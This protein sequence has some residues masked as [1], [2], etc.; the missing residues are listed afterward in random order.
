MAS[1][2]NVGITGDNSGLQTALNDSKRTLKDFVTDFNRKAAEIG[3]IGGK[4]G[5]AQR[6]LVMSGNID[7]QSKSVATSLTK[8]NSQINLA[9]GLYQING[10]RIAMVQA[11]TQAYT[12]TLSDLLSRGLKPDSDSAKALSQEIRKLNA[13]LYVL[14]GPKRATELARKLAEEQRKAGEAATKMAEDK[15]KADEKAAEAARKLAEEEK[16]AAEKAAEAQRKASEKMVADRQKAFVELGNIT[17]NAGRNMTMAVTAP[18]VTVSALSLKAYGDLDALRRGLAIAEG[19]MQGALRR[20]KELK[21][22]Y[23]LPGLGIQESLR[24]DVLLRKAGGFSSNESFNIMKEFGNAIALGGGGKEQFGLVLTQLAQMSTATKV[25]AT[26]LK[27]IIGQAPV[28]A[29]AIK[30]MFGTVN[31]E[32]ISKQLEAAGKGPKEFISMLTAE[33]AK[34]E[35]VTS[36]FKNGIE[37]LQ[38]SLTVAGDIVG[39]V[40]DR[41][42]TL[43]ATLSEGANK[44][45]DLAKWFEGLSETEQTAI[46]GALAFTAATGPMIYAAGSL[47]GSIQNLA[48]AKKILTTALGA[49]RAATILSMGP[50]VAI[51]AAIGLLSFKAYGA[52]QAQKDWSGEMAKANVISKTLAEVNEEVAASIAN[53]KSKVEALLKVARDE[54]KSKTERKTAIEQLRT[55]APDYLGDLTLEKI[56]TDEVVKSVDRYIESLRLKTKAQVLAQ[57][58][59]AAAMGVEREKAKTP[60]QYVTFFDKLA[61]SMKNK[62]YGSYDEI[63]KNTGTRKQIEALEP[64]IIK[65]NALSDAEEEVTADMKRLGLSLSQP[66][67]PKVPTV[68][69][70]TDTKKG[71]S[72]ITEAIN[73]LDDLQNVENQASESRRK[74]NTIEKEGHEQVRKIF[75]MKISDGLKYKLFIESIQAT[76]R[77]LFDAR[78]EESLKPIY[79]KPKLIPSSSSVFDYLG[80]KANQDVTIRMKLLWSED[81][82][83]L[84]D[85]KATTKANRTIEGFSDMERAIAEANGIDLSKPLSAKER[86]LVDFMVNM[87]G[88]LRQG[89]ADATTGMVELVGGLIAGTSGIDQLPQMLLGV[90]GGA[91]QQMGK[92]Y[93]SFGLTSTKVMPLLTN[94]FTSGYGAIAA[95]IAMTALGAGLKAATQKRQKFANGG[96]AYGRIFGV[97]AEAGEYSNARNNPEVIA[98]LNDLSHLLEPYWIKSVRTGM[99]V[100]NYTPPSQRTDQPINIEVIQNDRGAWS[101]HRREDKKVKGTR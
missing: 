90:I 100:Q 8:L 76:E 63:I 13:E 47:A 88:I 35:R 10:D 84:K 28:V 56:K 61:A 68:G 17:K 15:R 49:S 36:G 85:S 65:L 51:A 20:Q 41:N 55:I 79:N 53:E 72:D 75:A 77:K 60:D 22:I 98:P 39:R 99:G 91:F 89:A 54:T 64:L 26:D 11:K 57:Q 96:I 27:P 58:K 31:S 67:V 2:I 5:E 95:G 45:E 62:K 44:V 6:K 7:S 32:Q 21:S 18:L 4:L 92:A 70:D 33:L 52:I 80:V 93:I 1:R 19:S 71:H 34:S 24:G 3:N 66:I 87:N 25:L 14:E 9:N 38:D 69:T 59:A 74:L 48:N 73:L 50:I 37:N 97:N 23:E 83:A 101:A 12:S 81:K 16:K 42:N 29:D 82:S 43:T 94:P 78:R 40:I 30:R 46:L 86:Q